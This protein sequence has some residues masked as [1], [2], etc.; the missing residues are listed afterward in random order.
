M[1]Q[2][3]QIGRQAALQ[4]PSINKAASTEVETGACHSAACGT[5]E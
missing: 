4:S 2:T 1:G 5:V 3:W